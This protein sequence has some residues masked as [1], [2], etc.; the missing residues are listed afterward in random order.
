MIHWP[1]IEH[2][3]ESECRRLCDEEGA[4]ESDV[5]SLDQTAYGRPVGTP[6]SAPSARTVPV[7]QISP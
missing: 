3:I 1:E 2:H 4:S 6:R 5:S 7:C